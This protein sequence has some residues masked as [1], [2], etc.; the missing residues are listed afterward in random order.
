MTTHTGE[1]TV[2]A[3]D[4]R[5]LSKALHALPDKHRG[6]ADTEARLRERHLDLIANPSTRHT[7]DVRS[8]VVA[9]VRSTLVERGFTEVETPV[10]EPHAGGATARPFVTHHNALDADMV[11]RIALELPL[12]RLVVGGF[13]RV[14]ELG[15]V[16]RNEGLDPSHNPEFTLLEAYQAFA[17]YGDMME[18]VETIVSRA[19]LAATG[20]TVLPSGFDLAPPW[21]RATMASLIDEHAGVTMHPSMPLEEARAICDRLG[22]VYEAGWGAGK[23]MAEVFEATAEASL[24]EP[25]FVLDHPRE[26]SPLARAH[27]DDPWL[28]ERFEAYVGGRELAN[29]YSELN[30]PV[31][32]RERFEAEGFVDEGYVRALEYGLPPTGGLG[33]GI[34]RLVMLIAACSSIREAVLFPALRPEPRR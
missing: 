15:R 25:T 24:I 9:S 23:L 14:F 11:L 3:S 30:D 12:K 5:L 19:A 22:V 13:E 7:F 28:T 33:I 6:L 20:T 21:R 29:A 32:Q 27:R 17:D 2:A 31:D 34:D 4:V 10:L 16:F 1:L 18:L 8:A 26:I